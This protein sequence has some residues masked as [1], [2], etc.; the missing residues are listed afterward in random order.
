MEALWFLCLYLKN[1]AAVA[2]A[3]EAARRF[4]LGMEPPALTYA[5]QERL[6]LSQ[7]GTR[8]ALDALTYAQGAL[9][10]FKVTRS[11][12][13]AATAEAT[14]LGFQH[15]WAKPSTKKTAE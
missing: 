2:L 15:L 1:Y 8:T 6:G 5:M 13:K 10:W 12:H 7:R 11:G 4:K 14:A 3:V 9:S